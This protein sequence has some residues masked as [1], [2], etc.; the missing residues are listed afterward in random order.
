MATT[1]T[2]LPVPSE[3]PRDLKF[4]AGKIDE[5][6][7]SMGWTY[8]DRFGN[9]HYT[10]EGLRWLAQQAISA[11]GYITL[12]SFE[13]GNN[14]TLPNQVLRL[15]A[16][17]EYYRWDGALPKS[18][19]A[20]STP[21]TTGGIGPGA[22]LSVGDAALRTQISDPDGAI[23]YPQLQI[24]RW[25]DD[26]DVRG[27]GV[28]PDGTDVTAK[29]CAA[30]DYANGDYSQLVEYGKNRKTLYV[31]PGDY[32]VDMA[33]LTGIHASAGRFVIRCNVD[34]VG[35]IPNGDFLVAHVRSINVS[36]LSGK[37][38]TIRG[39]QFCNFVNIDFS[40][41]ITT[42]GSDSFSLPG[43]IAWGGGSYWNNFDRLRAGTS[44]GGGK[45]ILDVSDGAVNQNTFTQYAGG[46]ILLTNNGNTGLIDCHQN[47]FIGLD[48]AGSS[49]FALENTTVSNQSNIVMGLYS[50]VV[51][52]GRITGNWQIMGYRIQF[53]NAASTMSHMNHM[54]FSEYNSNQQG[55]DFL[56][57]SINNLCPSGDWST[58]TNGGYPVD[59]ASLGDVALLG[60]DTNEPSGCGR[61]YGF[62]SATQ[63]SSLTVTLTKSTT[64]YIRGAFYFRGDDPV[65]ISVEATDGTNAYFMD[66]TKYFVVSNNWRLYKVSAPTNDKTK[67]YRLRI[68]VGLGKTGLLG[69]ST[70]T[71][72]NASHL[73]VFCGW[74][75]SKGKHNT[76]PTYSGAPVGFIYYRSSPVNPPT[77]PTYAW[78]HKGSGAYSS[79]NVAS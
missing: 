30:L 19:P 51:G 64:G 69:S 12:D 65:Q 16:T 53:G 17:G 34:C 32:V 59:Y 8:T 21:L 22:W 55:G 52:N 48:T 45:L 29:L 67:T 1:P 78:V 57:A 79:I 41:N 4:N 7:T 58:I 46:G 31:P 75:K 24:A 27:W 9:K 18:V 5:F 74:D 26:L 50:E 40:G 43:L 20:G 10:I 14:L 60:N 6:V 15:E 44:A 72:Y 42:M 61:Y 28:F 3:S 54:I 63:Q 77:D 38:L 71:P 49:T 13:D 70:F 35:R 56:S 76:A 66:V 25:R 47:I 37:S 2:N 23:K 68:V 73:P 36:G 33:K 62:S 39:F 11:F